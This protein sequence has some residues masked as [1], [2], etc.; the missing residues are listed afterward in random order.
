VTN[1]F[2]SEG[3]GEKRYQKKK[4]TIHREKKKESEKSDTKLVR[5]EEGRKEK[6]KMTCPNRNKISVRFT[7]RRERI[8]VLIGMI[9]D[10]KRN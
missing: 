10:A 7:L 5:G 2:G 6:E 3:A 4:S 1:S 9:A 8:K